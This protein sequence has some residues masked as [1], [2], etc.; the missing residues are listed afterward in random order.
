MYKKSYSQA[1]YWCIKLDRLEILRDGKTTSDES[2][3]RDCVYGSFS[4]LSVLLDDLS[5][6]C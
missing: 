3:C 2:C 6:I 1:L 5:R 4:T